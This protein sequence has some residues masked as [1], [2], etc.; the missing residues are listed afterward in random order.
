MPSVYTSQQKSAIS[1]FQ[2][3]TQADRNTAVR[4]S[5]GNF[6]YNIYVWAW[7]RVLA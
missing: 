1:Q 2:T 5:E 4:V 7:S 3:F 6:F